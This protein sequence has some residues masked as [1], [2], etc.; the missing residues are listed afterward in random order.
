MSTML[1]YLL[2]LSLSLG[3]MYAFYRIVLQRFTFYRHNRWYLLLY[4]MISFLIPLIDLT[5]WWSSA[6]PRFQQVKEWVPSVTE[7]A[8]PAA[9]AAGPATWIMWLLTGVSVLLLIRTGIRL[10]SLHQL[11]NR[12]SILREGKIKVYQVED[13]IAPFSFGNAIYINQHRHTPG[14]LENILRHEFVHVR[15]RHTVDMLWAELLCLLN[16][17]NPAAWLIRKAIRQNLEFIADSRVLETGIDKKEYQYLLLQVLGQRPVA[18]GISFNVSSL[19]KRIAMM[20]KNKTAR[21]HLSWFLLLLPVAVTVLLSF[22]SNWPPPPSPAAVIAATPVLP[23]TDTV[24]KVKEVSIDKKSPGKPAPKKKVPEPV[25]EVV[26]YDAKKAKKEKVQS[27][28]SVP[29]EKKT[30][31][32]QL[33]PVQRKTETIEVVPVSTETKTLQLTPV[34]KKTK[35]IKIVPKEKEPKEKLKLKEKQ[36]VQHAPAK[37]GTAL[38]TEKQWTMA[39]TPAKTATIDADKKVNYSGKVSYRYNDVRKMNGKVEMSSAGH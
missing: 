19:K 30:T 34:E 5:G 28:E 10:L 6:S 38:P 20:N 37:S 22:R 31:T 16:W 26:R 14:E 27:V 33:A 25:I 36:T 39:A 17:Y 21:A 9:E 15:E 1:L 11:R 29:A 24:P 7:Y 12:A 3:V 23:V 32:L 8:G 35:E 4:S 18:A 13:D 2:K